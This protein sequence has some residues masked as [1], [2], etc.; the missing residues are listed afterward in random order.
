MKI[1]F[2]EDEHD[3]R[4]VVTAYLE[5][6]GHTVTAVENGQQALRAAM[7]DAFDAILMDVMMPVMDGLTAMRA[8]RE[9]GNTM[10]ALFLTAKG[11]VSDRVEGLDA[12]AD[13]YLT[14]P[15]ALEELNA[16]LRALD[17]RRRDYRVRILSFGSLQL[18]TEASELRARNAIGLSQKEVRLL[19]C[20]LSNTDRY[21][22]ADELLREVWPGESAGEETVIMYI[23]FLGD[24]MKSI[25]ADAFIEADRERGFRLREVQNV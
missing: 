24:K 21:I 18:D 5:L 10:P 19:C 20:L 14:K 8:I 6:Q 16:R 23:S 9:S 1:L 15:F 3:L 12:G 2:A 13:D 4:D 11:E 17:R 25:Q 7:S 22:S